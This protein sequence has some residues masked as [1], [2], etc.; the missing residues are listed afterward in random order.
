[1]AGNFTHGGN[2][3]A[4]ARG[5]GVAPEDL[6]D[7]SAS[8]NPL[9]LSPLV[10]NA[11]LAALDR[12]VHYP[13]DSAVELRESLAAFHR[14]SPEQ[15]V[16]GN[17]STELIYL[18]PRVAG[19]GRALIVGPAFAEYAAALAREKWE[20]GYH[21]LKGEEGF[22]LSAGALEERL[23]EGW[24]LLFLC[25]PGNPTGKL[26]SRAEVVEVLRLCRDAGTLLVLDEAF[27]DFCEK[28]SVAGLVAEEGGGIT[29]RSL[30]KFFA[31]PGLRLGYALG[32]AKLVSRIASHREPWSVNS[33]AQA[34]G[35][36]ALGDGEYRSNTL[37][38]VAEQRAALEQGL[39]HVPGLN[40]FHSAAN[41]ILVEI[42]GGTSAAELRDRLLA[43]RI[44]IRDCGNFK[45][46]N[47]R[48]F[49][50][51]VRTAEENSR[52]LA[53]LR[54]TLPPPA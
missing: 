48:F 26:L 1:M 21:L 34:A 15:V 16:V 25:N 50:I 4:V 43:S 20:V 52:L 17:G 23:A 3:F 40:P 9:G 42:T 49:R 30:T 28:D 12:V 22:A 8:I 2:V 53:A 5:L 10:R 33:L 13:D 14:V 36:A 6:L 31:I 29:L 7:F 18:L 35:L 45:G 47:G 46:L 44:L 51:A 27:I 41:F 39:A 32:E 11:V 38:L 37:A 24:D 19:G 54:E